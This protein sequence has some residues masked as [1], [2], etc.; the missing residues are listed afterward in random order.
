MTA[1]N[2]SF[3]PWCADHEQEG[4][5]AARQPWI[6]ERRQA[7]AP[8]VSPALLQPRLRPWAGIRTFLL[9]SG[10][11]LKPQRSGADLAYAWI[12]QAG[13]VLMNVGR[14]ATSLL[15]AIGASLLHVGAGGTGAGGVNSASRI[16]FRAF[17]FPLDIG[18]SDVEVCDLNDDGHADLFVAGEHVLVA[19]LGDGRGGFTQ[20]W[21]YG[22][23][24]D[25]FRDWDVI[26]SDV[27][28]DGIPD[29]VAGSVDF[30]LVLAGLGDGT[31]RLPGQVYRDV[32]GP[33]IAVADFDGDT[34]PDIVTTGPTMLRVLLQQGGT[35]SPLIEHSL[36]TPEG[37][38]FSP[39][40]IRQGDLDGNGSVDLVLSGYELRGFA[41]AGSV[42]AVLRNS[43]PGLQQTLYWLS[44]PLVFWLGDVNGD[45]RLDVPM[46]AGVGQVALW[47][48]LGDGT[49]KGA[50]LL[51]LGQ[52]QCSLP[53]GGCP[54]RAS[55]IAVADLN[56]DNRMDLAVFA[57]D[58][59]LLAL[60]GKGNGTFDAASTF[61]SSA[62]RAGLSI[63]AFAVGDLNSDGKADVV[64]ITRGLGTITF[65]L[66]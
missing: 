17:T 13:G 66:S 9:A 44:G 7:N 10:G 65:L 59:F 51:Q 25:W 12:R 55:H 5:L 15:V 34:Q 48:G 26:V 56:G 23:D 47:L 39:R 14:F 37:N 27:D 24:P 2:E 32:G 53:T 60:P 49:F 6:R 63:G 35:F 3:D 28:G 19:L 1:C 50:G 41:P 54:Y 42:L 58:R 20:S 30:L 46:D 22:P 18:A 61:T 33:P 52:Y 62:W 31:F 57:S 4:A 38:Y 29:V 43:R 36:L 64:V 8:A 21:S 40:T 11:C 45:G 16:E